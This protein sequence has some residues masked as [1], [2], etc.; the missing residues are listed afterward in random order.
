[1]RTDER[2]E[3]SYL[4]NF[5]QE[6]V[7]GLLIEYEQYIKLSNSVRIPI[8]IVLVVGGIM[9]SMKHNM[10]SNQFVFVIIAIIILLAFF[11]WLVAIAYRIIK[12]KKFVKN[13]LKAMASVQNYPFN[14]LKKEFNTLVRATYKGPKV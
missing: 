13:K 11:A 8:I 5:K 10:S 9:R 6:E 1:M 3:F 2:I 7:E 14:E 4:A 12:Q